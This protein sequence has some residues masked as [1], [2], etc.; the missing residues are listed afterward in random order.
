MNTMKTIDQ[1]IL[2]YKD[3]TASSPGDSQEGFVDAS[4]YDGTII[5]QY[6]K[7]D[8]RKHTGDVIY[9][10][11]I[12]ARKL[13]L[14]NQSLPKGYR[15]KVVYGYRHPEV[16]QKYFMRMK[17]SVKKRYPDLTG[18]AL[19]SYVHNFIAV[20]EVAGHPTG[21]AVDLTIIQKDGKELDMGTAIAEYIEPDKIKT[22]SDDLTPYQIK[23]RML[24]HDLMVQ[25]DFAPFYGEWWHFSYGD[26][27]WA[28]FYDRGRALYGSV[29][30]TP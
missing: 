16:Q 23:N 29:D 9:V 26:R 2:T 10:R 3:L 8:M 6:N 19:K 30:F 1:K 17:K 11:D 20:P 27:E 4:R 18:D 7:D 14:V 5:T 21:G 13:A 22:F 15:L 12:L 25:Q 28:I 24:L